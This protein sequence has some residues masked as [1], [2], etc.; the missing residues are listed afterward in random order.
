MFSLP[1]Q[2][3][4]SRITTNRGFTIL[5][6]LIVIGIILAIGGIVT[7][8][9]MDIGDDSD[10]NITQI[11]IQ[12]LERAMDTFKIHMKRYPSEEEGLGA[13]WNRELI[14]DEA[15]MSNWKG[16]YLTEPAPKDTWGFEWI[17]R[18]PSEVEGV[19]FDIVSVGPDG[20]EGTDD[21]LSNLDGRVDAEGQ[22]LDDEFSDF[23]PAG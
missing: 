4:S 6:L 15:A 12:E 11:K 5:E 2:R 10:R 18:A 14:E 19:A 16:P 21:D 7:V 8:N 1:T 3:R 13:L 9:F 23:S 17:Y 22:P 20:E